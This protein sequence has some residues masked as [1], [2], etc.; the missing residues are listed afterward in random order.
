[1]ADVPF[2]LS[3]LSSMDALCSADEMEL[4]S[5]WARGARLT[6][7]R[8]GPLAFDI[9]PD[10]GMN[11]GNLD[12]RGYPLAWLASVGYAAP[13]FY[14]AE[15]MGWLRTFSGG[16]LVTCGLLNAGDPCVDEGEALG[17]HG[18]ASSIP[19]RDVRVLRG[20]EQANYW[21]RVS[22]SIQEA[23]VFGEYLE[24]QRTYST[25]YGAPTIHIHDVIANRGHVS[26]PLMILY[27]MNFGYPLISPQARV[28]LPTKHV[29]P[30]D[31][32]AASR[33]DHYMTPLEPTPAYPEQVYYHTLQ[34][35]AEGKGVVAIVNQGIE[36][37]LGLVISWDMAA[38]PYFAQWNMFASGQYTIGLEPGN[39]LPEG[40]KLARERNRLEYLEPGTSKV[41]DL[42]ISIVQGAKQIRNIQESLNYVV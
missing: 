28:L 8:N 39:C 32:H 42:E 5:G 18:R 35:N 7:V 37:G 25:S 27:H 36:D 11:L 34:A 38:L 30:Y 12:Y 3:Y 33:L 24:L 17:L 41:I 16:A 13:T 19:A 31:E 22:G 14:E 15:G 29:H 1:M 40:R 23:R 6:R 20:W 9:L 10:R 21:I 2:P 26:T 4:V